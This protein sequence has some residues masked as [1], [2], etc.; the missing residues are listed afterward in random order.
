MDM[1]LRIFIDHM[2]VKLIEK[3]NLLSNG[4][5][6]QPKRKFPLWHNLVLIVSL[7]RRRGTEQTTCN[8]VLCLTFWVLP[9]YHFYVTRNV[10]ASKSAISPDL[11]EILQIASFYVET[12]FARRIFGDSKAKIQNFA[13][14]DLLFQR[15]S[16]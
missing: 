2:R 5:L 15:C 9:T 12:M 8:A 3:S 7:Y 14:N 10:I 16:L 1:I 4:R 13:R 11:A 6:V